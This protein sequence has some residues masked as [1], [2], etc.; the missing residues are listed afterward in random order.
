[1]AVE[2]VVVE[3]DGGS[4]GN[5]G[6]AG[7]GAV[8]IDP[9]TGAVLAER[10]AA[11]GEA[12]N[13]VA[14]YRGLIAGLEA[15]AELGAQYVHVRMDSKL[16]VEQMSGRWQIKHEGLRELAREAVALRQPFAEVTFTWIP[17]EQNK[18]ADRLANEA[19]D[20][21]A[22]I[23]PRKSSRSSAASAP[24]STVGSWAPP[25]SARTRLVIVRHGNTEHSTG[26]RFSGRNELALDEHGREQ[27]ARLASR[28]FG[29]V[30]AVVSSPLRRAVE[31]AE[32]IALPLGLPVRTL[33]DLVETD[34]GVWEGLT[35]AEAAATDPAAMRTW[36]TSPDSAP[37]GGESFADVGRRV[38]RAREELTAEYPDAAVVVVTHVTPIKMLVCSALEAPPIALFRLHVDTASVSVVD[39]YVDGNM[40]V[41]LVNDTSHL[42]QDG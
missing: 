15:A 18:H 10:A 1:V 21:A 40:S 32:A 20:A 29:A 9:V 36:R 41:K 26:G 19:M 4:R 31:T 8:V 11:I 37:P 42:R 34:F 23:A 13:N 16:V 3:A 25:T 38:Q 28:D 5:P 12:T 30:A 22:G 17:R 24:V 35:F 33:D 2:H 6:P 7:Y 39:Y 27:A 14:E